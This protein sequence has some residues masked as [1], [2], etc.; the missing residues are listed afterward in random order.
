VLALVWAVGGVLTVL[1]LLLPHAPY[2]SEPVRWGVAAASFVACAVLLAVPPLP[3]AVLHGLVATGTLV[4]ALCTSLGVPDVE[5]V[6]FVLPILFAFGAF[7]LRAALP[8]LVLAGIAY[9]VVLTVRDSE[10]LVEPAVAWTLVMGVA[11]AAGVAV[12]TLVQLRERERS[13]S[14]RDRRIA[15]VLQR[16]LLPERLPQTATVALAARYL[17]ATDEASVGGDLYDAFELPDGRLAVAVGDVEG[18]GLRA[19][20]MVGQVRASLR[21][22]AFDD[23]EPGRVLS[24]LNR[25]LAGDPGDGRH[26]HARLR[27][28]RPGRARR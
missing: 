28:G 8:H 14:R 2:A 6:F 23:G 11:G 7:P 26:D 13:A 25:V 9:A 27:P 10:D 24:R 20:A 18:K 4:V 12:G 3:E 15:E 1:T 19:A 16:T 5:G 17:P 22:L 21:A